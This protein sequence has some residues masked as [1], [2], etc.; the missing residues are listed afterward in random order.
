MCTPNSDQLAGDEGALPVTSLSGVGPARAE[1]LARL[2]V[3][4]LR[5]LMLTIP[6]R[7]E[8]IAAG[9]PIAE[10]R[11][12][13]GEAVRVKGRVCA[14]RYSR[15]GGRRS[16]L[17]VKLDDGTGTIDAL[18]FNQPW[19]RH[20]FERDQ[21][22][23][24]L[25]KVV[26]SKGPALA[27][28]KLGSSASPLPEAGTLIPEYPETEGL[29]GSYVRGL[30][31][32][33]AAQHAGVLEELLPVERLK[34]LSLPALPDAVRSLHEPDSV[35]EFDRA[36]K[37]LTFERLLAI[38]AR[39]QVRRRARADGC[40]PSIAMDDQAWA[41][42][43][44]RLEFTLTAGQVAVLRDLS[45]DLRKRVPMRRLLQGDVGSGKTVLALL[46]AMAAARCGQ[47]SVIMAPTE[48]L[49][50]QHYNG[51]RALLEEAGLRVA[52]LT[53]S[54]KGADR[55]GTLAQVES[56]AIDVI[57]GTH[58]LFSRKVAF[59][60]L[61]LCVI[62]E[63]HRF[64]VAQRA[65]LLEKGL[66]AHLLLM[67]ATPIP[68]TLAMTL[69]ADL[70]VSLLR[71]KP[72]GRG[73][74]K[75]SWVR[76]AKKRSVP[77]FL[78]RQLEA[79][80]RVY[81]V[82]P[83]IQAS[84]KSAASMSS[85]EEAFEKLSA[86]KLAKFGVE[87]VHGRMDAELRARNLERFRSGEVR[88]LVATTVIEVGVDVPEANVIV[89][90]NAERLG[91]SQL[92]QLRGRVGRGQRDSFCLLFAATSAEERMESLV[93]SNDGFVLAE[94]D[95]RRRG[96]GDLGGLRQAGVNLEGLD[97]LEQHADLLLAARDLV[98]A[99]ERI[100]EHYLCAGPATDTAETP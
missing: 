18:F 15:M 71:D 90:E 58:A 72:P 62:D 12:T 35:A 91:L 53:G 19:M 60:R 98:A 46:V 97:D 36:R 59:A 32:R 22:V 55:R 25:G 43:V 49:A 40:A 48:L 73:E 88:I 85:V 41:E 11:E 57:F 42:L 52:F 45:Q 61:G 13:R 77:A 26:E 5:D 67:T 17:R 1:A 38:Q 79:G 56:G 69:Y 37:R 80:G 93:A 6:R 34:G 64:G 29:A 99:D 4:N 10:A 92:H 16:L 20:Q 68:R 31:R 86:S 23:E 66:D 30:C 47:Q 44:T 94:D 33:V 24:L 9:I 21:T 78:K 50:E 74:I 28:P 7:I 2:G 83:R 81:W 14:K 89:I 76:G 84:E 39:A 100:A 63:Q 65:R 70:D 51:S 96:M 27:S 3:L 75:T 8:S 95:L 82:C 54:V 87:L